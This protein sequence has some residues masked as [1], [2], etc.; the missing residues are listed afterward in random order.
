M[1]ER[2]ILILGGGINGAAAARDVAR[3]ADQLQQ[4][5]AAVAHGEARL[6]HPELAVADAHRVL[7]RR[8][9]FEPLQRLPPDQAVV[10]LGRYQ[11]RPQV[12]ILEQLRRCGAEQGVGSF[13]RRV[14]R[15]FVPAAGAAARAGKDGWAGPSTGSPRPLG[16][17]A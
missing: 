13:C 6:L 11:A 12:R 1:D 14:E 7:A 15:N 10:P 4:P 2:P 5:A 8:A 17:Q 16:T 9:A 3:G